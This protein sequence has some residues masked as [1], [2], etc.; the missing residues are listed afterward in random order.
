MNLA[1]VFW[2]WVPFL[3]ASES[4]RGAG[5]TLITHGLNGNVDEWIIPMASRFQQR[6]GALG[7]NYSCYEFYF[8]KDAGGNYL[9]TQRRIGGVDPLNS[10]TGEIVIKFDWRQLANDSYSTYDVAAA[11]VPALL[12]ADFIPELGGKALA[13]LP[14]HL[15]GHSRGG[16][17]VCEMA[18]LL[19]AQGIWVDH[20]TTL[21]PH[22][23]NNDGFSD[24]PYGEVD[25]PARVYRN[26]LFADNYWQNL[27]LLARGEPLTGAYNRQLTY[28]EG[29]YGGLTA[30]HS[31]VHLWYHG[32]VDL[33]TPTSDTQATITAAER[34][35]WWTASEAGGYYAGFYYCLLAGG[36]RLSNAEPGGSGN[37]RISDGYNR[38]WD[39]GAGLAANRYALPANNGAWPNLIR[40]NLAGT[41]R[42]AVGQTI[43]MKLYYQS[44]RDSA[45]PVDIRIDLDDDF[46]PYNSNGREIRQWTGPATGTNEIRVANADY[47]SNPTNTNPGVYA[48]C[49]K[50]SDGIHTRYLYAPEILTLGPSLL[51]PKLGSVVPDGAQVRFTV[52]GFTGQRVVIQASTNLSEWTQIGTNTLSSNSV[53]CVDTQAASFSRRFYR[54]FLQPF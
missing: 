33:V 41:N 3:L 23:L 24:F 54:A 1:T 52:E 30:S 6:F 12:Q 53:Q 10:D 42:V 8:T 22:P 7:T 44:G 51:A 14:I 34:Q 40:F 13:E 43:S 5:V 35:T 29:G 19:G 36:D 45:Q 16:S 46:N 32:T 15:I 17:L 27:N 48:V 31:D 38:I 21:D 28:L 18:S 50:I 49:A 47:T 11:V 39:F 4:A 20:L 9:L 2:C 26:V 37:G 25:A